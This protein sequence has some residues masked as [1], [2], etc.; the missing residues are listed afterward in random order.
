MAQVPPAHDI[1]HPAR[2]VSGVLARRH[3]RCA[4]RR[5]ERYRQ[6]R[7][8]KPA[9]A[10]DRGPQSLADAAFAQASLDKTWIRCKIQFRG[11]NRSPPRMKSLFPP[12]DGFAA[13]CLPT[14]RQF[15]GQI[16][17]V[18]TSATLLRAAD[19]PNWMIGCYTRPWGKFDYRVA[20]DGIAEA[21]FK[22]V[23][24]M[25]AKGGWLVTPDTPPEKVVMIRA[26]AKAR[27]LSIVS[28]SG[29]AFMV[30]KSLPE[31]IARLKRLIDCAVICGSPGLLLGGTGDP[32]LA[33]DYYLAIGASCDYAAS[34]GVGL[35]LKPH[36]PA[37]STGQ[38]CR[39]LIEKVGSESDG[40]A[41]AGWLPPRSR[42]GRSP[43]GRRCRA[44]RGGSKEGTPVRFRT[45]HAAGVAIARI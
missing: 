9:P 5:G 2:D 28:L 22:F 26:E 16:M 45:P 31:G 3:N 41:A 1:L 34:K 14:G 19:R 36:G 21:G 6:E 25:T 11:N 32:E 44:P 43:G 39:L 40:P 23:G 13:Q 24:I 20:F 30:K 29:G 12:P 42:D 15:I 8:R 10:S 35:S 17:L 7:E 33:E 18:T 38:Q 27:G 4:V 37:N